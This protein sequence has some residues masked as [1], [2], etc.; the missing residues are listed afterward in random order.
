MLFVEIIPH[1]IW[2]RTLLPL[3]LLAAVNTNLS[4][5]LVRIF[6]IVYAFS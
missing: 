5:L 2:L 4:K 6:V 3:A 1:N